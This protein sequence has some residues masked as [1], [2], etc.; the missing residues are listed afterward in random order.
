MSLL[1]SLMMPA[2]LTP[3]ALAKTTQ[4]LANLDDGATLSDVLSQLDTISMELA[5]LSEPGAGRVDAAALGAL[6]TAALKAG[7]ESGHAQVTLMGARIAVHACAAAP[8]LATALGRQ[9]GLGRAL[10]APVTSLEFIEIAEEALSAMSRLS[11]VSPTV[12]RE[13]GDAGGIPVLAN[14]VDFFSVVSQRQAMATLAAAAAAADHTTD[15]GDAINL[16]H[17]RAVATDDDAIRRDAERA[18][19]SL[20]RNG[21]PTVVNEAA[22]TLAP[23]LVERRAVASLVVLA[24]AAADDAARLAVLAAGGGTLVLDSLQERPSLELAA[25]LLPPLVAHHSVYSSVHALAPG[26]DRP[27]GTDLLPATSTA[28]ATV[29]FADQL[30]PHMCRALES[31]SFGYGVAAG[32]AVQCVQVASESMLTSP[33]V[34]RAL[35]ALFASRAPRAVAAAL[36]FVAVAVARSPD[37]VHLAFDQAGVGSCVRALAPS[38]VTTK[39]KEKDKAL[40]RFPGSDSPSTSQ[41]LAQLAT[42]V[43]WRA[44]RSSKASATASPSPSVDSPLDD[45]KATLTHPARYR[46]DRVSSLI[47]A[48]ASYLSDASVDDD[49][50]SSRLQALRSLISSDELLALELCHVLSAVGSQQGYAL[51]TADLTSDTWWSGVECKVQADGDDGGRRGGAGDHE[52]DEDDE[53]DDEDDGEGEAARPLAQVEPTVDEG[54]DEAAGE[55]GRRRSSLEAAGGG[56][57]PSDAR[58]ELPPTSR[59]DEPFRLVIGPADGSNSFMLP[60]RAD[61]FAT[62]RLLEQAVWDRLVSGQTPPEP[63]RAQ[64]QAMRDEFREAIRGMDNPGCPCGGALSRSTVQEGDHASCNVCGQAPMRG[65][66][67]AC[68]VGH[69]SCGFAVCERCYHSGVGGRFRSRKHGCVLASYVGAP[70]SAWS[71]DECEKSGREAEG[72]LR[73]VAGCDYDMC[74]GCSKEHAEQVEEP[75]S[76]PG[77]RTLEAVDITDPFR[78]LRHVAKARTRFM[79]TRAPVHLVLGD[80]ELDSAV[81]LVQALATARPGNLRRLWKRAHRVT[82]RLASYTEAQDRSRAVSEVYGDVPTGPGAFLEPGTE[83]ERQPRLGYLLATRLVPLADPLLTDVVTVMRAVHAVSESATVDH[84]LRIPLLEN[85]LVSHLS[86]PMRVLFCQLPTWPV[87]LSRAGARFLFSDQLRYTYWMATT[88]SPSRALRSMYQRKD[89]SPMLLRLPV[90]HEVPK[91]VGSSSRVVATVRRTDPLASLLRSL[92]RVQSAGIPERQVGMDM[93]LQGAFE[94][95]DGVGLGPT[96]E[97]MSLVSHELQQRSLGLW[98]EPDSQAAAKLSRDHVVPGAGGL[99]PALNQSDRAVE[100]RFVGALLARALTD[101]RLTDL[102]VHPV[103]LEALA[104]PDAVQVAPTMGS[105][106][107]ASVARMLSELASLTSDDYFGG[108]V[109]DAELDLLALPHA[110]SVEVDR[111]YLPQ[112]LDDDTDVVTFPLARPYV[113]AVARTI[114]HTHLTPILAFIRQ[115]FSTIAPVQTLALLSGTDVSALLVGDDNSSDWTVEALAAAIRTDRGYNSSSPQV[116]Q[117]LQVLAAFGP[118]ERRLFTS[119]VTGAPRLPRGGLAGLATPLTVTRKNVEA[120]VPEDTVLPSASTCFL[121]LKLPA[122]SGP[123]VLRERLLYAIKADPFFAF[124]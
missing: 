98:A 42:K 27:D 54:A 73:C 22:A 70:V 68:R 87:A 9:R 2:S 97:L 13:I 103:L 81:P 50:L 86:H 46:A 6:V 101:G 14:I 7:V 4:R 91:G 77:V 38:R 99:W 88:I 51:D 74:T 24:R 52:E 113:S 45:L 111:S 35:L 95:E 117:L 11:A 53:E 16:F 105:I 76:A 64:L 78:H 82:Y 118:E 112:H 39:R 84:A 109:E 48:V 19:T 121:Q 65:Y 96:L 43:S 63:V 44:K 59:L 36:H 110:P 32:V 120:G 104:C 122:Y 34:T 8:Q 3:P 12:A 61:A 28:P 47:S 23:S 26:A 85:A 123:D 92:T 83:A 115:G 116:Q 29:A 89:V 30:L 67:Y 93:V 62:V 119:F 58:D 80:R 57:S 20:L 102:H 107:G 10:M 1:S 71:C 66:R 33:F 69:S 55:G 72:R 18:L 124:N 21:N 37:A 100:W 56:A 49:T 40:A 75:L 25:A 79:P 17:Q 15:L 114:L 5:H 31:A 106:V 60:M 41:W 108:S 90:L 94:G